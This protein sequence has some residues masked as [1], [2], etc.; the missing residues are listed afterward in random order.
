MAR[1]S[2]L[3]TDF[4]RFSPQEYLQEY[5]SSIDK[6]N[7]AIL[8]FLAEAY[9]KRVK[10]SVSLFKK[11]N[12]LEFG[13]GPTIY[14]LISASPVVDEI[15]FSDYNK[16]N[17]A[18]VR[19]WLKGKGSFNWDRWFAAALR[20]ERKR[21]D[22]RSIR[23]RENLLRKKI[24]SLVQADERRSHPLAH[25]PLKKFEIVSTFFCPESS[26]GRRDS[27]L[28]DLKDIASLVRNGGLLVTAS[29][30]NAHN[31]KIGSHLFP[32]VSVTPASLRSD[33]K[34][35]GFKILYLDKV[36]TSK[37]HGYEGFIFVIAKKN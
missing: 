13:G 5:Y 7:K 12:F 9:T 8:H 25:H 31:Y 10:R 19:R 27:Y 33:L 37:D 36:A 22:Q 23:E 21:S 14:S 17:L 30:M 6:E 20:L 16:N 29:L 4:K 2:K 15:T 1:S 28:K 24:V 34:S 32:A 3:I 18:E 35:L 11:V 26:T